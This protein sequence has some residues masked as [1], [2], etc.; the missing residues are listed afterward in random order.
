VSDFFA[1]LIPIMTPVFAIS[2]MLAVGFGHPIRQLFAPL[3]DYRLVT[4]ALLANFVLVP[5]IAW[6]WAQTF[7]LDQGFETGLLV[8]ATAAGAPFLI[9][10]VQIA[11]G[12]IPLAASLLVLF[13]VITVGYVPLALPLLV[14]GDV[15]VDPLPIASSLMWTMLAPLAIALAVRESK[16]DW[17]KRLLPIAQW[18]TT[19]S[20]VA[21]MV[22]T[23]IANGGRIVDIFGEGAIAGGLV[24]IAGALAA[25]YFFG[26]PENETRSTV[27]L[28]TGQRNMAAATVVATSAFDSD[29][30]VLV[31]VVVTS[32]VSLVALFP[33]AFALRRRAE[34]GKTRTG[35]PAP[36]A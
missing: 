26:T 6:L 32:M 12:N 22:A 1:D 13:L 20:L 24:L 17:A 9:K 36:A 29:P 3:K 19:P 33:V 8:V 7:S 28:A 5:L 34:G 2:S 4:M 27:G 10:L 23:F 21:V 15:E 25:G 30:N 11:N 18:F 35:H 31:M 16:A 14:S